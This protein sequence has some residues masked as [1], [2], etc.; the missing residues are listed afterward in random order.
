MKPWKIKIYQFENGNV[1]VINDDTEEQMG[2]L[3]GPAP[4][5]L[6]KI[7]IWLAGKL[8]EHEHQTQVFTKENIT[9]TTAY[10]YICLVPNDLSP[11]DPLVMV[12]QPKRSPWHRWVHKSCFHAIGAKE[13]IRCGKTKHNVYLV[14]EE[15]VCGGCLSPAEL[16]KRTC[17]LQKKGG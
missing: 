6:G 15:I 2:E 13:C 11:E 5:A 9:R 12:D 7:I 4:T 14:E 16:S 8:Q 17:R 10:C 1:S 3:C